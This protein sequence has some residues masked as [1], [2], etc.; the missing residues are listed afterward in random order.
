M[1]KIIFIEL[2]ILIALIILDCCKVNFNNIQVNNENSNEIS[3]DYSKMNEEGSTI[4]VQDF[5]A[6]TYRDSI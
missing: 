1:N 3:K 6:V 4:Y 2:V 5:N